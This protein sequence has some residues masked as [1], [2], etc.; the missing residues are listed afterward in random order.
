V[1]E[2]LC[3]EEER[4]IR[5]LAAYSSSAYR[6]GRDEKS[7]QEFEEIRDHSLK[8]IF[9][10]IRTIAHQFFIKGVAA[11]CIFSERYDLTAKDPDI[12]KAAAVIMAELLHRKDHNNE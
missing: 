6:Y 11:G 10:E 12:E 3:E 8:V 1:E 9:Q 7:I 4:I 5:A 2:L